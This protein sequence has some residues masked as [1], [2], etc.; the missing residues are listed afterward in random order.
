MQNREEIDA[1]RLLARVEAF[2]AAEGEVSPARFAAWAAGQRELARRPT[3]MRDLALLVGDKQGLLAELRLRLGIGEPAYSPG[4]ASVFRPGL[5]RAPQ[6]APAGA[7]QVGLAAGVRVGQFELKRCIG[8]GGM[9]E[10]WEAFDAGLHRPVALKFVLPEQVDLRALERFEREARA[11]GRL[12]HRNLVRTLAFGRQDE[13]AWIAQELVEGGWTLKDFLD[14]LRSAES[15]PKG[16]YR[17]VAELVA[18]LAEGLHSAHQVG[19][20]HRDIKPQNILIAPDDTPKVADF[21]LARV[22]DDPFRSLTGEGG[23]TYFYMSP[24]QIVAKRNGLDHRTDI[25]SLGVVLYEL[26]ALQRPFDGDTV[27]QIS[28]RIQF[29][30]PPEPA[31]IRSQCP[32]DLS[33]ICGKALAKQPE[34]RYAT[35]ADLA[36]DLRRHL[37]SQPIL[38]RPPGRW[39]K[40]GLWVR[41]NPTPSAALGVAALALVLISGLLARQ[42]ETARSLKLSNGEL[43]EQTEKA[44]QSSIAAQQARDEALQRT[45][46]LLSLSAQKDLDDLTAEAQGLWPAEPARIPELTEWLRRAKELLEGRPADPARGLK[47]R[48]SLAEH[49]AK[50][51]ELR[52]AALPQSPAE[53]QADRESHPRYAELLAK[54]AESLWRARML[55]L[56]PWPERAEIELALAQE[57]LPTD[58]E[59]LN[60]TAWRLIEPSTPIYGQEVRALLLAERA[61][62]AAAHEKG[63]GAIRDTLAWTLMRTGRL[64]EA[65]D[66]EQLA[67]SLN[68]AASVRSSAAALE[69][70]VA[71]WSE[72]ELPARREQ[73]RQL[74][75]EVALLDEIVSVRR[76]F[77]FDD[78]QQAWWNRQLERLI[79]D[80]EALGDPETGLL[81]NV[82][83]KPFGWGVGKRLEF[84]QGIAEASVTGPEARTRWA[85]AIAAIHASP[86][87]SGLSIE[88]QIG[89]LPIG[90][91]PAS[92]LWEFA[93]LQTGEPATRAADGGLELTEE[94]GLVFVLLPG[95]RYQMGAQND[96]RLPNFDPR[97]GEDERPVH[98]IKLSPFFI[99]KYEMTQGQWQRIAGVN[100][101]YYKP[102]TRM[103]P[104]LL[105]PVEGISWATAMDWMQRLGLSL[106][107]EAQWEYAARGGTETPWWTGAERESLRGKA[108]L[109]DQAARRGNAPWPSIADWPDLDD[110]KLVHAAAGHYPAN[111]FG[112]HEVAG[113]VWEWCLDGFDDRGYRPT[114]NKDPVVP[115]EG[116]AL[117]ISRGGS[118]NNAAERLRSAAR[119][120]TSPEDRD[121][122][123]GLRPARP[124]QWNVPA[125]GGA[126]Q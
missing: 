54:Q 84:A 18:Q 102:P 87:Y 5:R 11:G 2:L 9:G 12:A 86:R 75:T 64:Q 121:P 40:L 13:L 39:V 111:G 35:M 81:G 103:A 118:F 25:F 106:P 67:L 71:A 33:V 114:V 22:S 100:P 58:A 101:S 85:A 61:L 14:E 99:S 108:N 119:N 48:P 7:A 96:P 44:K 60:R 92:G 79:G 62:A 21:G 65:L 82:L 74:A 97:A 55:G 66:S 56:E 1:A 8:R 98:P 32:T 117:R 70:E 57:D 29:W 47:R 42:L 88:P 110:G 36:A 15:L 120:L 28:E 112:L 26:L 93:H 17:Q 59:E 104:S 109:A 105:H 6:A 19:V 37:G 123:L 10:V 69:L 122:S 90:V 113:N 124:L 38:A 3:W 24:E 41:R 46:D 27:Q 125:T 78:P 126:G 77:R 95:G 20:I 53:Q 76:S 72:A 45:E 23:G 16:Y 116:K 34:R 50:L 49:R 31:R 73:Q 83:A 52:A 115:A 89:L 4:E 80:L 51:A 43:S 91:D 107:S 30:D 68:D 94:T 63:R